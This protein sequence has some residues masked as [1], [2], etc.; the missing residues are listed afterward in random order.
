MGQP[1][2]WCHMSKLLC[3]Q[4]SPVAPSPIPQYHYFARKNELF[5][6][7]FTAFRNTT[8]LRP[9]KE[10]QTREVKMERPK[11]ELKTQRCCLGLILAGGRNTTAPCDAR[12]GLRRGPRG[13][14][15]HCPRSGTASVAARR[16]HRLWVSLQ[17]SPAPKLSPGI[18][19]AARH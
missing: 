5:L 19:P 13:R 18:S 3:R 17:P 1:G 12:Q 7:W 11:R 14:C 4:L 2:N 10:R 8:L 15:T 9:G 6:T 16:S